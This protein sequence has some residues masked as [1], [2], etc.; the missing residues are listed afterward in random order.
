MAYL[1][2]FRALVHV[3]LKIVKKQLI[4]RYINLAVWAVST[5]FVMSY[6]VQQF[7]MQQ[8]FGLIQA[9][10]VLASVGLFD[11]YG[12]VVNFVS[13]CDGSRRINYFLSLPVPGSIFFLSMVV[14]F[15]IVASGMTLAVI[16][17]CKVLVWNGLSLV[18]VSWWRLLVI[19]AL[20]SIFYGIFSLLIASY[21]QAMSRVEHVWTRFIFPL[22]F[23]GGFQ[24]SW[25]AMA[26]VFPIFGY[27]LLAN[28]VMLATEG[29]RAAMLGQ[30]GYLNWWACCGGLVVVIIAAWL[31]TLR[32]MRKFLDYVG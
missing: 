29:L 31:L 16:P 20:S 3:Q 25:V 23:F 27:V 2:I 15:A 21:V 14:S 32:R 18:A 7:G 24:F 9:T 11:V 17:L 6:I 8:S 1:Q 4:D 30:A 12:G 19:I 26:H 13:D 5:I 10:G 22:W 28:P